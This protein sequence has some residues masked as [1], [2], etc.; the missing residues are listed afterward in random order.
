MLSR[1]VMG[2][3]CLGVVW[4]TALLVAGAAWQ[5]LRDLLAVLARARRAV[6]GVAETDLAEWSVEQIGRALDVGK[7]ARAIG[8]HDRAFR[9]EIF[10]GSVRV[11]ESL[12]SV[13]PSTHGEVWID[14]ARRLEAVSGGADFDAAYAQ[15]R[16][17]KGFQRVVR[18]RVQAGDR[19]WLVGDDVVST[20]DPAAF[21]RRKALGL[22]LF[23][24]L[25]LAACAAA[26]R[27]ALTLP[28]FGT[29]SIAGAVACLAFFL[30]VTPL[31]VSLRE[32]ARRPHEAFLRNQWRAEIGPSRAGASPTRREKSLSQRK[33]S[34][35]VL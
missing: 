18:V 30:G 21:C 6:V 20:L 1:E 3:A 9:S 23:I 26:T 31:A 15:A 10:G 4:V 7:S 17:A 19:V 34:T 12:V 13:A 5:D 16:K 11:G 24:P 25:E 8:F 29:A 22:A 35:S 27:L 2:V 28:H 14:E 33:T 32:G